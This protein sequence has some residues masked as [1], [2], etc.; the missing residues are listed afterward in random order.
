[1]NTNILDRKL[2]KNKNNI[3]DRKLIKTNIQVLKTSIYKYPGVEIYK[4]KNPEGG[5]FKI[6]IS[7]VKY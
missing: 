2:R 6:P 3:L 4:Y 5:N 7:W 1:M